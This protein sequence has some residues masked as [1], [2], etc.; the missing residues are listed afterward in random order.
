MPMGGG[1]FF[2]RLTEKL[3]MLGGANVEMFVLAEQM[4]EASR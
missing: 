3:G 1:Q 4:K 2:N